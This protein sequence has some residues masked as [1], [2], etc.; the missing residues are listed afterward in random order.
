MHFVVPAET[1]AGTAAMATAISSAGKHR[2][3]I[4]AI[5]G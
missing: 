3:L 2:D 1:A 5:V 4:G